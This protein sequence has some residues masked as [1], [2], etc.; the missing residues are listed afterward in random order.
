MSGSTI[1]IIKQINH[2]IQGFNL[3]L[4]LYLSLNI[5]WSHVCQRRIKVNKKTRRNKLAINV[6]KEVRE[7]AQ[8]FRRQRIA[9]ELAAQQRKRESDAEQKRIRVARLKAG[10]LYAIRVFNW[11]K[12]LKE[13]NVGQE[14]MKKS[15]HSN[16]IFFDGHIVGVEPV[17]LGISSNGLFMMQQGWRSGGYQLLSPEELAELVNT[18]ILKM[19]SE[20]IDSDEVWKC[21]QRRFDYLKK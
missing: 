16:L 13:S 20:W 10:L 4:T 11:A 14:L 21:I 1:Y 17:R 19:A 9:R 18:V 6:P 15:H 12:T 5:L 8:K 3:Y 2:K 7:L